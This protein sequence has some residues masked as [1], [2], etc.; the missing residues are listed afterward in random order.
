MQRGTELLANVVLS[1]QVRI[2]S[3]LSELFYLS[4]LRVGGDTD[5]IFD[6]MA[7]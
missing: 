1:P 3:S 7:L 6:E 4:W 2:V 5:L